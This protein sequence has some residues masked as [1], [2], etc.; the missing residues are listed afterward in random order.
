MINTDQI[1]TLLEHRTVVG[2]DGSKIAKIDLVYVDDNSGRPG[3]VTIKTGMFGGAASFVPLTQADADGSQLRVPYDKKTIKDAPQVE[4]DEH[5]SP[6][7]EQE[8]FRYYPSGGDGQQRGDGSAPPG[9][10]GHDTSGP[11]TRR[12][13]ASGIGADTLRRARRQQTS[14]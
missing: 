11:T 1:P 6:Q 3:W 7:E 14:E 9:A 10:V 12:L 5:L 4:S 8:L 2:D 13:T